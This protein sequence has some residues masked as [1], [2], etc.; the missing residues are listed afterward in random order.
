MSLTNTKQQLA[1]AIKLYEHIESK[2]KQNNLEAYTEDEWRQFLNDIGYQTAR[3]IQIS[4]HIDNPDRIQLLNKKQAKLKRHKAWKKQHKK[5]TRL[6]KLQEA[7]RSAKWIKETEMKVIMSPSVIAQKQKEQKQATKTTKEDAR[8]SK[9][10]E[11]SRMLNALVQ[12]RDLRR[13]KLESKGHFFAESGNQFFNKVKEWHEANTEIET[14]QEQPQTELAI[15]PND[16]WQHTA[17]DK[18]AYAYWCAADQTLDRLLDIRRQWDHYILFDGNDQDVQ[19][20]VPP[21]FVQP[22]PPANPIWASYLL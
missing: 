1:E 6:Q 22:S 14:K 20:K 7:R 2:V 21:M 15:H 13:K 10:R 11:L 17:I 19:H 3:L 4:R 9:V 8:K 18:E 16:V 5:R 12:L